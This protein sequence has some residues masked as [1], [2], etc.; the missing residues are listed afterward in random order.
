MG[1][2][3][4][5]RVF[6]SEFGGG[7]IH[8]VTTLSGDH[9][10]SQSLLLDQLVNPGG[11]H[12][13]GA[14]ILVVA[15][16]GSGRILEVRLSTSRPAASNTAIVGNLSNPYGVFE[17]AG[18]SSQ[19]SPI[20]AGITRLVRGREHVSADIFVSN[21]PVVIQ[22]EPYPHLAGCGGSWG[23]TGVTA[24]FFSHYALGAVFDVTAGGNYED[25]REK[26]F[27]WALNGPLGMISDPLDN[28]LYVVEKGS[29]VIK[30]IPKTGG[31][32]RFAQPLI[33][34]FQEP[35]CIRFLPDGSAAYVCDRAWGAVFR[36]DLKYVS[37]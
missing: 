14:G 5:G 18:E 11:I 23:G 16:S 26:R 36:L 1:I 9:V 12:P 32:S 3:D 29:G 35:S 4:D 8:G 15:D 6:V 27:A 20:M 24:M 37:E 28:D 17:H 31:Y 22:S 25:F 10:S 34:G 21:F 30:R 33:A 7:S 19:P 2:T 13:I